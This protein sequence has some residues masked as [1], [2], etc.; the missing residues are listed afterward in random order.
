MAQAVGLLA[1]SSH[2]CQSLHGLNC[3]WM[4]R[5]GI[6]A[7]RDLGLNLT[8]IGKEYLSATAAKASF[9][10]LEICNFWE[11]REKFTYHKGV[12]VHISNI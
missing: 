6:S 8:E 9:A 2:H 10:F 5:K 1:L 7:C 12:E 3:P 11:E 4:A